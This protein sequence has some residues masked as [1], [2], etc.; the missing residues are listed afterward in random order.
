[1]S[2]R[3]F[4]CYFFGE[5]FWKR[6][7]VRLFT[8]CLQSARCLSA[9]L[10]RHARSQALWRLFFCF[11]HVGFLSA[12]RMWSLPFYMRLWRLKSCCSVTELWNLCWLFYAHGCLPFSMIQTVLRSCWPARRFHWRCPVFAIISFTVIFPAILR[13]SS[14]KCFWL[15]FQSWWYL[16]WVSTSIRLNLSVSLKF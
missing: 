1:M 15:S 9:M 14:S 2:L 11:R 8:S 7:Y 3:R 4:S 5:K 16:L 6:K 10:C 12:M 13:R